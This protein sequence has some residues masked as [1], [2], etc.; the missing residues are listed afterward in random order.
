MSIPR[1][2]S[3]P[4]SLQQ[5]F[6]G[7]VP[8]TVDTGTLQHGL[9]TSEQSSTSSGQSDSGFFP[10]VGGGE[11]FL[12]FLDFCTNANKSDRFFA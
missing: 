10:S 5:T 9:V 11:G 1:R 7:R 3:F 6:K 2:Y 8:K 12:A 4:H